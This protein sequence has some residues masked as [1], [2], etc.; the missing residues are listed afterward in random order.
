MKTKITLDFEGDDAQEISRLTRGVDLGT[1]LRDALG[2]F[3]RTR[4]PVEE[5]V[6]KRYAEETERFKR[7]K[8]REVHKRLQLADVLRRGDVT[9]ETSDMTETEAGEA[10][11]R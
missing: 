10:G 7:D 6:V 9:I 2:E 8:I 1:L 4:E 5:Y 11:L 3:T